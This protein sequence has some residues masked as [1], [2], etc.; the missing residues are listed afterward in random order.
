MDSLESVFTSL[1]RM[2]VELCSPAETRKI[3][4]LKWAK[5]MRKRPTKAESVL[6][7]ALKKVRFHKTKLRFQRVLFG[8]IA[9]FALPGYKAIIE[10]DGSSHKGRED[11]DRHRDAVFQGHGWTTLRFTNE[12]VLNNVEN[13]IEQIVS[14]TCQRTSEL[15]EAKKR[16]YFLR[17]KKK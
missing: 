16:R 6:Y 14:F 15:R 17:L 9:D 1:D 5:G 3:K 11:Y 4:K 13:V 12:Q 7:E 8:Y 10:V 2:P